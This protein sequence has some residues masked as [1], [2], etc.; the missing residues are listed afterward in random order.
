MSIK[1]KDTCSGCGQKQTCRGAYEKM[2]HSD[3]PNVTLKVILAFVLPIGVFVLSLAGTTKWLA[4]HIEGSLL[5]LL[6]FL[7]ALLVT[8]VFVCVIRVLQGPITK[9][10][11]NK[12]KVNDGNSQ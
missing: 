5:T 8:F 6:S 11:C 9:D 12:G 2:G 10:S 3:V 7:S 4:G 1:S